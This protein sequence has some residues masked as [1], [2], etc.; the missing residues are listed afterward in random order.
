MNW[1]F[2]KQ[3]EYGIKFRPF[4]PRSPHLKGKVELTQKTDI[5]EFYSIIDITRSELPTKLTEWQHFYD[6]HRGHSALIGYG[7][8][9]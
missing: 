6:W 8:V 4:Q 9:L 3:D 2:N 7:T 1:I 5:D